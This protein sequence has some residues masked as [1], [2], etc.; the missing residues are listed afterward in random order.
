MRK[1]P[2][3]AGRLSKTISP[4]A[5]SKTGTA[6]HQT[7][8][9]CHLI[10]RYEGDT[11]NPAGCCRQVLPGPPALDYSKNNRNPRQNRK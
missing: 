11:D 8:M 7:V 1:L 10:L 6:A 2:E 3:G 9:H 5:G 4:P